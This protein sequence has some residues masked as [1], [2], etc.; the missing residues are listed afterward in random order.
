MESQVWL[1]NVC[2]DSTLS[3]PQSK[4]GKITIATQQKTLVNNKPSRALTVSHPVHFSSV[5]LFVSSVCFARNKLSLLQFIKFLIINKTYTEMTRV[6]IIISTC[7][8]SS[9]DAFHEASQPCSLAAGGVS[10]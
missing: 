1:R 8:I 6:E 3:V 7:M 4:F 10:V 2:S 9:D 5:V